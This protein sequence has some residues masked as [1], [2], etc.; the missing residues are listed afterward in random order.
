[1]QAMTLNHHPMGVPYTSENKY[2]DSHVEMSLYFIRSHKSKTCSPKTHKTQYV[3]VTAHFFL[4]LYNEF[5][6]AFP[7]NFL[8]ISTVFMST[9][10]CFSNTC[11]FCKNKCDFV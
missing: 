10:L 3:N 6:P 4:K 2:K 5:A 1:M 9:F 11:L 8:I 7:N